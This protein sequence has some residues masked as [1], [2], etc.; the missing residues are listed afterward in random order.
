MINL[1]K[2]KAPGFLEIKF[3]IDEFQALPKS[4][5]PSRWHSNIPRAYV[6]E[7]LR[8]HGYRETVDEDKYQAPDKSEI[9][10]TDAPQGMDVL[11]LG[12]VAGIQNARLL[13]AGLELPSKKDRKKAD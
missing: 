10:L 3:G 12:P 9:V 7:M 8:Q 11:Y 13:T 6:E 1:A 2:E 5:Y 4:S